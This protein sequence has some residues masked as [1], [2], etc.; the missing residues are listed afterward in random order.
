MI[1]HAAEVLK[2]LHIRVDEVPFVD[3]AEGLR[4]R[5][6]QFRPEA[7]L[8]VEELEAQPGAESALHRHLAPVLGW[9]TTGA[10]GHDRSY[11]YRPDSYIF[12]TPGVVHQFLNGPAITRALYIEFGDTELIDPGS[13]AVVSIAALSSRLPGYLETCEEAGLPRPNV[14]G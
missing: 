5:I 12:E 11:S 4:M 2:T 13:G 9:T 14:L 8:L 3:V 7:S 1:D 10:W 6:L